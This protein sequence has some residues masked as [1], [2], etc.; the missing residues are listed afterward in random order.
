MWWGYSPALDIQFEINKNEINYLDKCLEVLIVGANDARHI[1]K[2][3]AS[4]YLHSDCIITYHVIEPTLEQVARSIL[5]LSIFLERNLGLQEATRY[6]LEIF[7]NTL[8]RPGTAKYLMKHS[9]QLA[10]IPTNSIDC[11]WLSLEKFKHKDKDRLESIFKF[12]EHATRESIPVV[13]YWDERVRRAL[14]TR[15]DYRDGV[16]DW[17]Y[18]MIL[19]SKGISNLTIQEYRFWRN[20]GIAFTWLEGELVRSNPTLLSNILQHGPGFI[21]YTYLGDIV[22]GP[23][24]AWS[25]QETKSHHTKYRATDITELEIMRSMHEIR[26]QEPFCEDLVASHRDSSILNGTLVS[27]MPSNEM[28]QELWK[29]KINKYKGNNLSWIDIKNHKVIFHPATCLEAFK[30]KTEYVDRFDFIWVAHNMTEQLPNLAKSLKKG[31]IMLVELKKY[32]VEAREEN[33]QTFVK[34]LKNL[35]QKNGLYEINDINAKEHCIAKFCKN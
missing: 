3:L 20:N 24:F 26:T 8:I 35:A 9:N 22:N 13:K 2:T 5:L 29:K 34:E 25:L 33:L 30:Y 1:T 32:L 4:S 31:G 12:W 14:K 6:Y 17:D 15:Y 18:Y 10:D 16:F 28:E 21:H 23:F 11:P 19:K 7:G 27:E